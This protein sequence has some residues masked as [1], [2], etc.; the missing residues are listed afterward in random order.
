MSALPVDGG[1]WRCAAPDQP[2]P[3]VVEDTDRPDAEY[4]GHLD[5]LG[6]TKRVELAVFTDVLIMVVSGTILAVHT[7]L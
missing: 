2:F 7:R 6:P 1:L 4:I 3:V 5:C